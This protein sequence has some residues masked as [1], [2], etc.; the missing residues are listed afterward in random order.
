M[1]E[2]VKSVLP[3]SE[4]REVL[5]TYGLEERGLVNCRVHIYESG[6]YVLRQGSPIESFF[7]VIKG[8]AKVC[9]NAENGKSL[10]LCSYVSEGIL[11]DIELMLDEETASTTVIAASRLSCIAIPIPTNA[12]VLKN[13]IQLMNYIGRELSRKLLRSSDAHAASAL[14]SSEA[15]LCS[16]ILATEYKGVFREYLTDAAQ[17]VGISYR[18]VFRII[19]KLCRE[20]VLE[21]TEAGFRIADMEELRKR[22]R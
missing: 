15:R 18:H 14:L 3:G 19:N 4:E 2:V 6:E 21:K 16:Y 5:L 9:V 8:T 10:V 1:E 22:C 11:G 7:V 13:N 12:G 17:S 20:T